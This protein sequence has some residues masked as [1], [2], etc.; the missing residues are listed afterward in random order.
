MRSNFFIF[1]ML[2]LCL[3]IKGQSQDSA[4]F[5]KAN[6]EMDKG[7]YKGAIEDLTNSLKLNPNHVSIYYNRALCKS[8]IKDFSDAI[9]D[10]NKAILL[11]PNDTD[12]YYNRA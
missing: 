6:A 1:F 8:H 3:N 4:L 11:A 10:Y 7:D 5:M 2:F 12:S 9:E